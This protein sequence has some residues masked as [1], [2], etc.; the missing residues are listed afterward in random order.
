MAGYTAAIR[1]QRGPWEHR[2]VGETLREVKRNLAKAAGLPVRT[3]DSLA[4]GK[5]LV[6]VGVWHQA[7]IEPK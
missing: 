6:G 1:K 5:S 3:A 2:V 7:K 4:I